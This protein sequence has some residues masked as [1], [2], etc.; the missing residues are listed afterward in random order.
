[1]KTTS[2]LEE[3]SNSQDVELK[4]LLEN[5]EWSNI[6][7]IIEELWQNYSSSILGRNR[8]GFINDCKNAG[9]HARFWE[10]YLGCALKNYGY[11]LVKKS[12]LGPDICVKSPKIWIEAR[13]A[14]DGIIGTMQNSNDSMNRVPKFPAPNQLFG[15]PEDKILLRYRTALEDKNSKYQKY[16][17]KGVIGETDPYIIALNA[18]KV[19]FAIFDHQY[20]DGIIPTIFKALFPV[21]NDV[22]GFTQGAS[23]IDYRMYQYRETLDKIKEDGS[24]EPIDMRGFLKDENIGISGV[25]FSKVGISWLYNFYSEKL[26]AN[27]IFIHN[28]NAKNSLPKGWLKA[29][30]EYW[31]EGDVLVKFDHEKQI[32]EERF[33]VMRNN[34]TWNLVETNSN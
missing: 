16:I 1:M 22:F 4:W 9:F 28:P 12:E 23:S 32:R 5:Q 18:W 20:T 27:F 21:G 26:A 7:V 8:K 34:G 14:T 11:E 3:I 15:V 2:L 13:I 17:K 33:L 19:S 10:M 30:H 31:F 6:K 29:G 24:L 25:L